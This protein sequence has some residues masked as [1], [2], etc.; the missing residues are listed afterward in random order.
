MA[1]AY[2][3]TTIP[4]LYTGR[5]AQRLVE[6]TP[7]S[8]WRASHGEEMKAAITVITFVARHLLFVLFAIVAG[9]VLWTIVYGLLLGVAVIWNQGLGGPLAYPTGIMMI[10]GV[11]IFIGW[12]IFAPASAIGAG[13]CRVFNLPKLAAIPVVFVSAFAL[14]YL[15][16]WAYIMAL[17]THPMP[18]TWIVLKNFTI[19]LSL[20]LGAY[21][22]LTEGPGALFDA[23]RRWLGCRLRQKEHKMN[24]AL[25]V[26]GDKIS[27]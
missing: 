5:P 8:R 27:K 2:I 24:M 25:A 16:Y 21:W 4:S 9:C 26:T 19:F 6:T 1:T 20:P 10:L 17:T 18:S 15:L 12:G 13:F 3:E 11:T 22:W 23:F 7:S 14:S